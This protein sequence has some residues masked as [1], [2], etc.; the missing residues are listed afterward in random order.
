MNIREEKDQEK[1]D[2]TRA[3]VKML[4]AGD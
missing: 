1:H 2:R 4:V 3:H